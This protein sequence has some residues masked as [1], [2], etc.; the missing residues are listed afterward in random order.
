MAKRRRDPAKERHWRQLLQRWRSSG[1]SVRALCQAPGLSEPSLYAW[2]R[3]LAQR[4]AAAPAPRSH[5]AN[6][7]AARPAF[8]P[9]HVR[10]DDRTE[11]NPPEEGCLEVLLAGQ[12]V[13]RIRR[14]FDA[15]TL[16]RLLAVLEPPAC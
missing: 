15:A 16:Q 11:V 2:R 7:R 12:R 6:P 8:V 13:L 9:V 5:V 4:D 14:G 1:L 10:A 3:I